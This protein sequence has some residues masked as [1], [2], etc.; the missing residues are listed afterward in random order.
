MN[1]KEFVV[2]AIDAFE[3]EFT[4]MKFKNQIFKNLNAEYNT[5][6]PVTKYGEWPIVNV[7]AVFEGV[8]EMSVSNAVAYVLDRY[9]VH[10]ADAERYI[11]H[12]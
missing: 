4:G 2:A 11:S 12:Q 1:K 7:D 10:V 6:V 3:K 8:G 9:K 5:I